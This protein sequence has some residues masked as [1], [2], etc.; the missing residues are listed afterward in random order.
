MYLYK[1]NIIDTHIFN[2]LIVY[3]N[4][5]TIKIY[6]YMVVENICDIFDL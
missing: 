2:S 4:V 1:I 3:S 5:S 6:F